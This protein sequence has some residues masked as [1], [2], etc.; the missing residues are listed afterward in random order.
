MYGRNTH[1]C[2]SL[3]VGASR[4]RYFYFYFMKKSSSVVMYTAARPSVSLPLP[5]A[6]WP[7][8]AAPRYASR[9]VVQQVEC[10]KLPRGYG[11]DKYH[12]MVKREH[13]ISARC[14]GGPKR[15]TSPTHDA[16]GENFRGVGQAVYDIAIKTPI[17]TPR[18]SSTA[19]LQK[20]RSHTDIWP[21]S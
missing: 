10:Q 20:A 9:C 17:P 6:L 4:I 19:E 21:I 16:V 8:R 11:I 18:K 14:S 12:E 2:N 13:V 1:L 5:T 7:H 3:Q 15:P